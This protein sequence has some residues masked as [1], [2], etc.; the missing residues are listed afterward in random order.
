MKIPGEARL[1]LSE[2]LPLALDAQI[3][4]ITTDGMIDSLRLVCEAQLA[5]AAP[6]IEALARKEERDMKK[7]EPEFAK[8]I[9][10]RRC[11]DCNDFFMIR[12][13]ERHSSYCK[14]CRSKR[15]VREA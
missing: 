4:G 13:G 5:K 9:S 7:R 11:W 10:R 2:L 3:V 1:A 14:V 15:P 12:K 8:R 6:I